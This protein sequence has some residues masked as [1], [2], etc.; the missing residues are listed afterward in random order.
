MGDPFL[1]EHS[2]EYTQSEDSAF[3]DPVSLL[4]LL[5]LHLELWDPLLDDVH[6]I[7]LILILVVWKRLYYHL[8]ELSQ[9]TSYP[10]IVFL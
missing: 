7:L 6:L 1:P 10:S 9:L 2:L 4:L 3:Q 5:H 8:K